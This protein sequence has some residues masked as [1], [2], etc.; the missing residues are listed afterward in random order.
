M[1]SLLS[2]PGALR[3]FGSSIIARLPVVMLSIGLIVH[4]QRLTGS[5]SKFGQNDVNGIIYPVFYA[6]AI[7]IAVPLALSR[8]RR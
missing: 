3:L 2:T 1:Q 7:A 4:A 8:R 5:F 6:I